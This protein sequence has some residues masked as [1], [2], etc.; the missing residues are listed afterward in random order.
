MSRDQRIQWTAGSIGGA[1]GLLVGYGVGR[2]RPSEQRE[3]NP[4][5]SPLD[6]FGGAAS[7]TQFLAQAVRIENNF[8]KVLPRFF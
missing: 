6:A 8:S 3:R 4:L 1:V 5:A 7:P 2:L